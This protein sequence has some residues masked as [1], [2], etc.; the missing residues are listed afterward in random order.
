MTDISDEWQ[1]DTSNVVDIFA[2]NACKT[3]LLQHI[4]VL[5]KSKF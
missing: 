2:S 1:F 4:G 3:S 5:I